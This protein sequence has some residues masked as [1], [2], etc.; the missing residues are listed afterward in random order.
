M[1]RG[2]VPGATI[3]FGDFIS[4]CGVAKKPAEQDVWLGVVASSFIGFYSIASVTFGHLV[5]R[6]PPF[7]LLFCGLSVWIAAIFVSGICSFLAYGEGNPTG[8]YIMER[9]WSLLWRGPNC[10]LAPAAECLKPEI[11]A[12]RSGTKS[13]RG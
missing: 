7:K 3:Q 12:T 11:R 6:V 8:G 13:R 1:D 9:S 10:S 5:H 4:L 2:I